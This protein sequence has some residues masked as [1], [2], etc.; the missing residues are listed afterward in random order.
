LLDD[1]S[2][3]IFHDRYLVSKINTTSTDCDNAKAISFKNPAVYSETVHTLIDCQYSNMIQTTNISFDGLL[4][5]DVVKVLDAVNNYLK[6]KVSLLDDKGDIYIDDVESPCF[7]YIGKTIINKSL[8]SV[9][10][11]GA[12]VTG[13]CTD[14]VIEIDGGDGVIKDST[15][16]GCVAAPNQG[17]CGEF[18]IDVPCIENS[19][20]FDVTVTRKADS[21]KGSDLVINQDFWRVYN[22]AGH[23]NTPYAKILF[24]VSDQE[25]VSNNYAK[26][27]FEKVKIE[28][29][30]LASL[31][32]NYDI[33]TAAYSFPETI[34]RA[35]NQRAFKTGIRAW[36]QMGYNETRQSS[37]NIA[38]TLSAFNFSLIFYGTTEFGHSPINGWNINMI[39]SNVSN[40]ATFSIFYQNVLDNYALSSPGIQSKSYY[41]EL[42]GM[43]TNI[44]GSSP[45]NFK[46]TEN[47]IYDVLVYNPLN[48]STYKSLIYVDCFDVGKV[49]PN[50]FYG[51]GLTKIA[52]DLFAL[53]RADDDLDGDA[54]TVD[55]KSKTSDY[56]DL[57][58]IWAIDSLSLYF[59]APEEGV[60]EVTVTRGRDARVLTYVIVSNCNIDNCTNEY[61]ESIMCRDTLDY[62]LDC[63]D[64]NKWVSD[65]RAGVM[66]DKTKAL[67]SAYGS[68]WSNTLNDA[69]KKIMG[70]FGKC[71]DCEDDN[72]SK[73]CKNC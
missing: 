27:P 13:N 72:N 62:C 14:C 29:P 31:V 71:I 8:Q 32:I 40:Y 23:L 66:N 10:K 57:A 3:G 37:N 33:N 56:S 51:P 52:C 2:D 55:I 44:G 18:E 35:I 69:W 20:N 24:I 26:L 73:P 1:D 21:T 46:L 70:M 19:V 25:D 22:F 4:V 15:I 59:K 38:N 39:V 11:S 16:A 42:G 28:I 5:N 61:F 7:R 48:N 9:T 43:V 6:F 60:Y 12:V 41:I 54:F 30:I 67:Q 17:N 45:Y 63:P 49:Y 68:S 53:G 47:G 65:L 58:R 64:D 36:F 50:V 34:C